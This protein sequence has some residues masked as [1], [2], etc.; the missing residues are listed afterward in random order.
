MLCS[1]RAGPLP[2]VVCLLLLAM[3]L[4]GCTDGREVNRDQA[5]SR[6]LDDIRESGTLVVVTRNAPT[7]WYIGRDGDPT[8]PEHDLVMSFAAWLGVEVEFEQRT[9]IVDVMD[10]VENAEADL[11]A[12]GL[13]I[14]DERRNRFRFGPGYQAVTQQVVCRRDQHQP[15]EIADLIGLDIRVI[16]DSSYVERLRELQQEYPDLEWD[17]TDSEPTEHLL[18]AVWERR[19]DCTV[20][21]STIVDINRRY[22]PE[23]IAPLNLTR[24]QQLGWVMPQPRRDLQRA[25]GRW[26]REYRGAGLLDHHQERYYGFF[27]VFDYVD[28]RRFIRRI[29]ERYRRYHPWFREAARQ[30]DL[31]YTLLAAQAYQE[32]HWR[33]DAVSPT[34]VRGMMMLTQPTARE[35]GVS[36]RLDARQSIFGGARYLAELRQRFVDE[37]VEPDRTWLA[38]AAYNVGRGHLHDAQMLARELGLSP[39]HWADMRQVLPLLANPQY[40]NDL[41]YGYARGM[42]PVRYVARVR[43]YQHI[44]ENELSE[45]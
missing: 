3:V 35:M 14:T 34:G 25:V 32:S 37:V 24:E 27:E 19:I 8:G 6:S 41:R 21:D 42:E 11:A 39:H 38:L 36:N 13:T 17:E 15:E 2:P 9:T 22:Y 44:L 29:D 28:T 16:A 12:A 10:A 23:L 40:Y 18:Q 31:P 1:G 20:A 5:P 33:P 45:E 43:E 30:Y 7:T 4:A 26:L